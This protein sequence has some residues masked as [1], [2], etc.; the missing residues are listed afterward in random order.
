MINTDTL[1]MYYGGVLAFI[2]DVQVSTS[3]G[4]TKTYLK[5]QELHITPTILYLVSTGQV[6][7]SAVRPVLRTLEQLEDSEVI[8]LSKI[9][10]PTYREHKLIGAP[11]KVYRQGSGRGY[12]VEVVI[13]TKGV[14]ERSVVVNSAFDIAISEIIRPP[15]DGKPIITQLAAK[16]Q[17]KAYRWFIGKHLDVLGLIPKKM[18]QGRKEWNSVDGYETFNGKASE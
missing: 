13:D 16:N 8:S 7:A 15:F 9:V 14:V 11:R 1:S 4:E 2:S 6:P 3:T 18:A 10:L 12:T 5:G 17:M